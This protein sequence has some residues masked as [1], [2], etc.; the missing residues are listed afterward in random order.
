MAQFGTT[1]TA[2]FFQALHPKTQMPKMAGFTRNGFFEIL[3]MLKIRDYD[4]ATF[5][6]NRLAKNQSPIFFSESSDLS[7]VVVTGIIGKKC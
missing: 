3:S 7:L 6:F 4:L 2:Q 5:S 1:W